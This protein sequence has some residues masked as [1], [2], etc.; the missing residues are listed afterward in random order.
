MIKRLILFLILT[1]FSTP[2]ILKANTNSIPTD[3]AKKIIYVFDQYLMNGGKILW[4]IDEVKV[5]D[6]RASQLNVV[7]A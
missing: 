6:Y 5:V 4:F 3:T 7:K 2:I 1:I